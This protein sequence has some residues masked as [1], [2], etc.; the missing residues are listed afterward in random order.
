MKS[1]SYQRYSSEKDWSGLTS[2]RSSSRRKQSQQYWTLYGEIRMMKHSMN[3]VFL[4][5]LRKFKRKNWC[6]V[7]L[8]MPIRVATSGQTHKPEI[9]KTIVNCLGWERI[10]HVPHLLLLNKANRVNANWVNPLCIESEGGPNGPI[11]RS[12]SSIA[13]SKYR[14]EPRVSHL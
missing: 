5:Q 11:L 12:R 6:M 10:A 3:Q 7:K 2:Q 4:Q 14:F 9:G 1:E 13:I 8:F